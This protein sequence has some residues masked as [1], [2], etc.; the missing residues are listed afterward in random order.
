MDRRKFIIGS[1]LALATIGIVATYWPRRWN[2]IVIHHSAG[3]YGS[4]ESLQ[5]VHRERQKNDPIDAIPYHYLI[6]NGKGLGMGQVVSDWRID[7]H[8]WGTH[9]SANNSDRNFR[10]IG[11][12]LVGNFEHNSVQQ[13]QYNALITLCKTLMNKYA[14]PLQNISGHGHTPGEHTK[15]PGKHFPMD[16]LLRDLA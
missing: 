13:Q 6:G 14:I 12:C 3:D 8:I 16:L 7:Y 4:L 9:V 1:S 11:I 5:Q 2:Y 10:G 15:C